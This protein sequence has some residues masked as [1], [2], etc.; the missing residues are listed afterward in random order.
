MRFQVGDRVRCT[1]SFERI[2]YGMS[3]TVCISSST[4]IGVDWDDLYDG[5]SCKG[6]TRA[7]H[8]Y[9]IPFQ[10]LEHEEEE[11]ADLQLDD[12]LI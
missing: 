1:K 12:S 11:T 5:H 2:D 9:N 3:G 6:R 8:G 4:W 10:F 7:G